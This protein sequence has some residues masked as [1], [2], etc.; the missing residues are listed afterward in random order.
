MYF[1]LAQDWGEAVVAPSTE[2]ASQQAKSP[3]NTIL[4][5]AIQAAKAAH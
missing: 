3:I 5:E 4:T 2:D 1:R